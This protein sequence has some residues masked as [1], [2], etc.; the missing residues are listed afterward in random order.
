MEPIV[1]EQLFSRKSIGFLWAKRNELDP[2]QSEIINTIY[3]GRK[4]GSIEGIFRVEY[5]LPK[6]VIGRLG[7]GR[8]YGTKGSFETLERECRGTICRDFYVDIDVVNC[9]PVILSQ[10]AQNQYH[11]ELPE[12]N[13]YCTQRADFLK[14]IHESKESAKQAIFKILYNG[15]NTYPF[16][17]PM[18]TEIRSFTKLHL[19]M[20]PSYAAL[21][22]AVRSQDA[23]TYGSFLSYILQTEERKVMLAMRQF[24]MDR[25]FNVDVLAYDGIMVRKCLLSIT[26]EYLRAAEDFIFQSTGYRIQLAIK[27]FEYYEIDEKKSDESKEIAPKV[28]KRDYD[29]KKELFEQ[30]SF[31]YTPTST[32]ITWNGSQ[33]LQC[34]TEKAVIR[35]V[36][37][38]FKHSDYL[39]DKTSFIK[40]WLND[41]SRR[42]IDEINMKPC[43]DPKVFSPPLIY[44]YQTFHDL[45]DDMK[46][47][48]AVELF[49]QLLSVVC[50]HH[51][52]TYHYVLSW[53]AHIFQRP[54]E[55]P[56]TA[57]FFT[58]RKGCGKDTL[59]DFIIQW[60]IGNTY[61]HNYESTDQFW[62]KHDTARENRL[63]VKVEEVEGAI[64]RQYA[65]KFK[66]R[67]TAF[68][69][70][71]NPKGDKPRTTGHYC[72]YFGTTN[73]PQP[74]KTEEDERRAFVI[75]CST[76]WLGNDD[77]WT[78]V[79]TTLFCPKG[80]AAI[81]HW[82]HGLDIQ[83]WNPRKIPA[84][85]YMGFSAQAEITSEA[86]FLSE[87]DG[88]ECAMKELYPQYVDH[89]RRN[90]LYYA[91]N[92]K[93]F[94]IKL[95]EFIRDGMVLKRRTEQ[96]M[97]YS[98]K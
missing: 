19:M 60:L 25:G 7:Y 83:S 51:P 23:N 33:L 29:A 47:D 20:D 5:R 34:S 48:T 44:R 35:F 45:D 93:S 3:N 9:H 52:E 78:T 43:D 64:N 27:P 13:M 40:L 80:A 91:N 31:F 81:G 95:L 69:V 12:V 36:E 54:F 28:L 57:L 72:R 50:G 24:F 15:N 59:G 32:V 68:D 92:S 67:I 1:C 97:L 18:V 73:E 98:K 11:I 14:Q 65:S 88:V 90:D 53:I 84:T 16:L 56:K 82:L 66:S 74:W 79:R 62:D 71:V 21:L 10:L 61:A 41:P 63:F 49:K 76:E 39:T 85:D 6:T 96:G 87:W 8:C 30:S 26:D 94:G 77:M 55:N 86:S 38:D 46:D 75:P 2:G 4:K 70:T 17:A 58:G 89:C 42:T 22:A 37:Y